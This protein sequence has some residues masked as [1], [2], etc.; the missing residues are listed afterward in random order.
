MTT[1]AENLLG[2]YQGKLQGKS[3]GDN[4]L[5]ELNKILMV[6]P[7]KHPVAS[8]LLQKAKLGL[9]NVNEVVIENGKTDS[10]D[11]KGGKISIELRY[12]VSDM[13][14]GLLFET[15]NAAQCREWVALDKNFKTI[16]EY[17]FLAYGEDK[18]KI[19]AVTLMNYMRLLQIAQGFSSPQNYPDIVERQFSRC[20]RIKHLGR[21]ADEL[22]V[23]YE[24]LS[25]TTPHNSQAK[26]KDLKY[27]YLGMKSPE[28]AAFDVCMLMSSMKARD[29]LKAIVMRSKN[30]PNNFNSKSKLSLFLKAFGA[31]WGRRMNI[32]E[33]RQLPHLWLKGGGA[34]SFHL[35]LSLLQSDLWFSNEM[36]TY[37]HLYAKSDWVYTWS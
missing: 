28:V 3:K 32:D 5:R 36:V 13:A 23:D 20:Q 18:T 26:R 19:E 37:A 21:S 24:H 29:K 12:D 17:G 4:I 8:I 7:D 25:L 14:Y 30:P 35:D 2:A 11:H 22:K 16:A 1:D 9:D 33:N 6:I 34:V 10:F 27:Q 15:Y 31:E